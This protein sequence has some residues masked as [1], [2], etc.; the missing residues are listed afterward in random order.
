MSCAKLELSTALL[1]VG[2]SAVATTWTDNNSDWVSS[3]PNVE[4]TW[5][6]T[7]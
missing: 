4:L 1:R 7:V 3:F 5:Y 2:E 6:Q